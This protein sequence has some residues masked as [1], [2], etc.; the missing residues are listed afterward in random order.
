M[1]E[2]NTLMDSQALLEH[3]RPY[4][5]SACIDGHVQLADQTLLLRLEWDP[6]K[7][8]TTHHYFQQTVGVKQSTCFKEGV[9]RGIC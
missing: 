6:G 8:R 3:D 4:G 9:D 1:K 7:S 2:S 5:P